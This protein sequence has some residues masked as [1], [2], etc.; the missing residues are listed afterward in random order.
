MK[1]GGRVASGK[2][3]ELDHS[4]CQFFTLQLC[5]PATLLFL[6]VSPPV[7]VS[8]KIF[9]LIHY[10]LIDIGATKWLYKKRLT[11]SS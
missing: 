7:S 10:L 4:A 6:S 1:N 3:A 9:K 2:V 8:K 5:N 11:L